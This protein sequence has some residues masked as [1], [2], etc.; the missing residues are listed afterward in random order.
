MKTTVVIPTYNEAD[1]LPAVVGELC[2]L[3]VEG[4]SVLIVDDQ[5]PDGTGEVADKLAA[6][7]P[8]HIR[9][10]HRS[11]VRGLGAAYV[12]GLRQALADGAD[13]IVQMDA[14]FSH[15]PSC[16]PQ[17]L[18]RIR[19]YDVVVGSRYVSGGQ[20]DDHWG[21]GRTFLSWFANSIYVRAVLRLKVHDATTGFKLWR[22]S[23]LEALDLESVRSEGYVF[24]VEMAYL[25]QAA[26]LRVLEVPITFED[27]RIGRSRLTAWQK[28]EAAW[29]VAEVAWRHRRR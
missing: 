8:M 14:D 4:L 27:R 26:G 29:R 18:E 1:N 15:S 13:T 16:I 24:H 19:E 21:L 20:L 2:G 25:A 12:E 28:L 11:G 5:S 17:F 10:I 23:A 22:R 7:C 6:R 3:P 9:V